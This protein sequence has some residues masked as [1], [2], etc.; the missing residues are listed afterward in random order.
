[1]SNGGH[2]RKQRPKRHKHL[3]E[4]SIV[5][6]YTAVVVCFH[7]GKA[8]GRWLPVISPEQHVVTMQWVTM[9]RHQ[10]V[11]GV[12]TQVLNVVFVASFVQLNRRTPR[13]SCANTSCNYVVDILDIIW[14]TNTNGNQAHK[15]VSRRK[16][17]NV[18]NNSLSVIVTVTKKLQISKS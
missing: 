3:T 11:R 15:A 14:A 9:N 7:I 2:N 17:V 10:V 16:S 4:R 1:M 6:V 8:V 5:G 13:S 18:K 12:A